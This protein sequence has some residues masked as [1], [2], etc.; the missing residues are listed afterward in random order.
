MYTDSSCNVYRVPDMHKYKISLHDP[1]FDNCGKAL[2]QDNN[3]NEKKQN[4][5]IYL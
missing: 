1:G 3:N 2:K 5:G 4:I